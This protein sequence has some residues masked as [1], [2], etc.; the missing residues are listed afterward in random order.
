MGMDM[1]TQVL[2][3]SKG[4]QLFFGS[5]HDAEDWFTSRLGLKLPGHTSATDFILDQVSGGQ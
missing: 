3:M 4:Y 2:V 5:P 1:G